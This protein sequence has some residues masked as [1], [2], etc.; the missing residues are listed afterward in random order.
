MDEESTTTLASED[1]SL[2]EE[3]NSTPEDT[4]ENPSIQPKPQ[5]ETDYSYT[6][7]VSDEQFVPKVEEKTT[8][9]LQVDFDRQVYRKLLRKEALS[10][11]AVAEHIHRSYYEDWNRDARRYFQLYVRRGLIESGDEIA[12]GSDVEDILRLDP[13]L[14]EKKRKR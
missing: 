5:P 7:F 11:K 12:R 13:S 1:E 3:E 2:Q 6:P 14:Y 10:L 4:Q 8:R 9:D